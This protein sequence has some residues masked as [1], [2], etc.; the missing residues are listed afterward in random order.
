MI[1]DQKSPHYVLVIDKKRDLLLNVILDCIINN[2]IGTMMFADGL[3][4][5]HIT[6]EEVDDFLEDFSGKNHAMGWCSDP[7]CSY[8]KRTRKTKKTKHE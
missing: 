6:E 7:H 8:E 4:K 3:K 1:M 2:P 5:C